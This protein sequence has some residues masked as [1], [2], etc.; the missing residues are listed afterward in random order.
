MAGRVNLRK[1]LTLRTTDDI[2]FHEADL[3]QS[4]YRRL[5]RVLFDQPSPA[6]DSGGEAGE[7]IGTR[8][9]SRG[10]DGESGFPPRH[11]P[12]DGDAS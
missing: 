9:K 11:S 4:D 10:R 2:T 7:L 6:S 8:A 3:P 5:L 1:R 12:V